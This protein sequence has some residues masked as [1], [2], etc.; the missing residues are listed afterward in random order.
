[1]TARILT[2]SQT[3]GPL[4]G[5]YILSDDL[6]SSIRAGDNEPLCIDGRIFD[7]DGKPIT[8]EMVVE[9]W[10]STNFVRDAL[11]ADGFFR[12][13]ISRPEPERLADGRTL[14]PCL[15]FNAFGRGLARQIQT[16]IYLPEEASNLTDPI[17]Q[18][19]GADAE[20]L[21]AVPQPDS[22]ALRFDVELQGP[23]ETPFFRY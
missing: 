6:K 4:F 14:A 20:R 17:L 13:R 3:S 5:H 12:V 7:G 21:V 22:G 1:V 10:T 11:G 18:M 8:R 23:C 19:V 15:Q 9:I 16:R 2:P